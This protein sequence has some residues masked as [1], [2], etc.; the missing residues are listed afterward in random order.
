[1]YILHNYFRS[2]TSF[3]ARIA[4]N[5]KGVQYS[6]K[7][8]HLRKGEQQSETYLALN[9]QGLV[10]TLELEDGTV[11]TQSMAILEYLDSVHAEAAF[12]PADPV[13]AAYVRS[14]CYR[15][16][17]DIHPLNNLRVLG[18]LGDPLGHGDDEKATWFRHWMNVEFKSLEHTLAADPRT[19]RFCYGDTPTMADVCLIPQ[20]ING[21]RFDAGIDDYPT[22]KRIFD[23]AMALPA[24]ERAAPMNQ[25]DAE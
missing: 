24:F 15:I 18:Y 7:S 5:L 23:A 10:P 9:D 11:I 2:S 16:A 22:I 17:C 1:M 25:P 12:L 3:R 20:V 6:Q 19:G 8:Y 13:E 4:L 21:R 14:L